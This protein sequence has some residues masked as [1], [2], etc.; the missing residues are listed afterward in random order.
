MR[1]I[2]KLPAC[3]WGGAIT[4]RAAVK[5]PS[6]RRSIRRTLLAID[7]ALVRYTATSA[8]PYVFRSAAIV[9][10]KLGNGSI[11]LF[12][13]LFILDRLGRRGLAV[14][15]VAACNA[16]ILQCVYPSLKRR[17]GRARPYRIDPSLRS[18]LDVLDEHSF[19]S[20]H[21]MT[22][23]AVLV[24][25]VY[26]VPGS[27]PLGCGLLLSMAWARVASAHHFPSDVC[28]GTLV[29]IAFGYPLSACSLT[30]Q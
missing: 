23:A 25:V 9:V 21:V 4:A 20:G 5:T 11:Y 17:I 16:A 2:N 18:L 14:A 24:P 29:G 3:G 28:A 15:V 6:S 12:V 1:F 27:G 19:P 10:S 8:R 26:T 7:L 30:M 22:L 13:L